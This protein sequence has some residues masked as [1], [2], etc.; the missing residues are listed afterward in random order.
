MKSGLSHSPTPD[1]PP[2]QRTKKLL[3]INPSTPF[4]LQR[5][6][7]LALQQ[8]LEGNRL[9]VRGQ[10]RADR[11]AAVSVLPQSNEIASVERNISRQRKRYIGLRG[12]RYG[13]FRCTGR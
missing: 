2:F 4:G 1:Y 7:P 9:P 5:G 10:G 12:W 11:V 3:V 8:P 13:G 6:I